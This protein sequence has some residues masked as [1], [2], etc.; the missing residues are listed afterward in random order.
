[1]VPTHTSDVSPAPGR[2]MDLQHPLAS[3]TLCDRHF[4]NAH[5]CT[6]STALSWATLHRKQPIGSPKVNMALATRLYPLQPL[7]SLSSTIHRSLDD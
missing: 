2:E 6:G 5:F 7:L 3:T 1:M 4:V